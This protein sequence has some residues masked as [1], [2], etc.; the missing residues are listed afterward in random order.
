MMRM[1]SMNS[2]LKLKPNLPRVSGSSSPS[3]FIYTELAVLKTRQSILKV[4]T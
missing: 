4:I 2:K 3:L 1:M